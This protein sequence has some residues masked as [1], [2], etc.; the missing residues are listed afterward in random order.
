MEE[1]QSI[2]TICLKDFLHVVEDLKSN[3]KKISDRKKQWV[4]LIKHGKLT[5]PISKKEVAYCSYDFKKSSNSYHYNFYSSDGDLFTVDHI[6]PKSCGGKVNAISNLQPMLKEYN[7]EKQK[8][9][10]NDFRRSVEKKFNFRTDNLYII[11]DGEKRL[12]SDL[13]GIK[14]KILLC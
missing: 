4:E 8:M 12:L 3:Y 2:I 5:C 13:I 10:M 6:I 9:F 1:Y 7:A 14:T 11:V